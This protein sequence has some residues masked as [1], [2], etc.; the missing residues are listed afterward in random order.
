MGG[1]EVTDKAKL[2][3]RRRRS[4]GAAFDP[5]RVL[6]VDDDPDVHVMTGILLRDFLFEGRSF[7]PVPARSA[8]EALAI[9]AADPDIPVGLI[10]VVME[11]PDSGLVLVRRIREELGNR[12]I[13]LILRTGQPGGA[14]ERDV[15]QGWDV[16][17][18]R[19]KSEMTAQKLFTALVAAVR[20]WRDIV[21]VSR[22]AEELGGLNVT[23]EQRV[24]DRTQALNEAKEAAEQALARETEAKRQLRQFLSMMS[25]EFRTPLAVIDSAAQMLLLNAERTAPTRPRLE[26]I[27][28]GV[29]RLTGLID[30]CLA[31][32][33]LESGR[34]V[35]Q[36]G[37]V[38]VVALLES[39]VGQHRA[40]HSD[41]EIRLTAP[42][43]L[44]VRGDGGLL[45]LVFD[46]LIGN[47]L[48]YS[49]ADAP[50]EIAADDDGGDATITIADR[51][52]GIPAEDLGRVF[53]RFFRAGNVG[54]RPGTGIGLHMARQIVE[55]H[56]GAIAVR[57][58]GDGGTVFT[59]T[60][61]LGATASGRRQG[62]G[63]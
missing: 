11:A 35:L 45:G 26:T 6:V 48:K 54:N 3:F 25:H 56:G 41:R 40:A 19:N 12:R 33:Q 59:V 30:T 29:R 58:R 31:D 42:A 2:S 23:L 4:E 34:I 16:N 53:D 21:R 43:P 38:D 60:L 24:A 62:A 63:S 49:A 61:R 18:Y 55:M 57:N 50:V 52:L 46:N 7:E 44:A 32:E 9:V 1:A 36:D 15:V 27:R 47:A 20:A 5:W 14:P 28:S 8:L 17:D 39:A 37:D 51:G 10:D 13:R 22:M